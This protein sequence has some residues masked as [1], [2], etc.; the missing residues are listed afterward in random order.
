MDLDIPTLEHVPSRLRMLLEESIV[1][2]PHSIDLAPSPESDFLYRQVRRT[3]HVAELYHENSKISPVSTQQPTDDP[4]VL[5]EIRTW[6]FETA[7]QLKADE[8]LKQETPALRR[9]L[10]ALPAPLAAGLEP[11]AEPGTWANLLYAVDLLVLHDGWLGRLVPQTPY[12]W[13]ERRTPP[14]RLQQL[15][16]ALGSTPE[17]WAQTEAVVFLVACPWRYMLLHG[18]RGYRHTLLDIGRL[19]AH[20][21]GHFA[22]PDE[23]PDDEDA[24]A[25]FALEVKQNFYDTAVDQLLL[26]DGLE[27]SA[28]AVLTFRRPSPAG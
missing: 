1:P 28:Y 25:P 2:S 24:Q 18:P 4:Q 21:E 7:Y 17:A 6:F 22:A 13:T 14:P 12:L 9:S 10:E 26:A 19:L 27:R 16:Q 23:A 3:P 11:F 8:V 20:F 5:D 15:G